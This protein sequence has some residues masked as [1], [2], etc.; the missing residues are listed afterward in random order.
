MRTQVNQGRTCGSWGASDALDHCGVRPIRTDIPLTREGSWHG[1][2]RLGRRTGH[3]PVRG[4]APA[5][6]SVR[7]GRQYVRGAAPARG[8]VRAGGS[9]CRGS[10]YVR[11]AAG[12]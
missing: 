7:A 1:L 2:S 5:R 8:S 11:G 9:T 4:A 6:G 12:G 10:Q 3:T